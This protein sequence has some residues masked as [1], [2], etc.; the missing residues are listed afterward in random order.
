MSFIDFSELLNSEK[1]EKKFKILI[2]D[3]IERSSL[4]INDIFGF[5]S[6]IIINSDIRTF[7]VGDITRIDSESNNKK[8]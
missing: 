2:V 7:F 8:K 6:N 3:D 5:F 1:I 4:S